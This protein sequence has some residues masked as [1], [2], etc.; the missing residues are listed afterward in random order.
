[1][2]PEASLEK[3]C[4]QHAESLGGR[5]PKWCSPGNA[6]VP[7]RIL[8]LPQW[9]PIFIEFK[10]PSGKLRPLQQHWVDWLD[11]NGFIVRV[12]DSFDDFVELC[13]N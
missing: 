12:I 1:M 2:G 9:D 13:D 7:D 6:G 4:R 11:T 5:M 8:L 3:K 10:A